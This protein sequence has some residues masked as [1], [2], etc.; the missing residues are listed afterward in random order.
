VPRHASCMA[1][2]RTGAGG[3]AA[4]HEGVR[5]PERVA[6][7]ANG[8]GAVHVEV[9]GVEAVVGVLGDGAVDEALLRAGAVEVLE[10]HG[11]K[12][13]LHTGDSPHTRCSTCFRSWH[14]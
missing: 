1:R 4:G 8:E 10:N 7:A 2:R 13:A 12:N 5:R 3:S 9:A 6:A 14:A 11:G